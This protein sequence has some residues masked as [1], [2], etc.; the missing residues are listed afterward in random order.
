MYSRSL[1]AIFYERSIRH[2]ENQ[3]LFA[4]QEYPALR[5]EIFGVYQPMIG[6]KSKRIKQRMDKG[7]SAD[8]SRFRTGLI[9]FSGSTSSPSD[10]VAAF[11]R[12]DKVLNES[13]FNRRHFLG[14]PFQAPH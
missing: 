11:A 13:E 6:W 4:L 12:Y 2:E 5:S 14:V 7:F 8:L 9:T 1:P 10:E 3:R